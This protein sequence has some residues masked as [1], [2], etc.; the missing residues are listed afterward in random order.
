MYDSGHHLGCA[1]H[2]CTTLQC[3]ICLASKCK[4]LLEDWQD[5]EPTLTLGSE[6]IES[7]EKFVYLDR[8]VSA[9]DD[10]INPRITKTGAAY[11]NMGYLL[12]LR[13]AGLALKGL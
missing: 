11:V 13:D 1:C 9:D 2:P 5:P 7:F 8:C 6:W 12:H 4:V 10:E 3:S